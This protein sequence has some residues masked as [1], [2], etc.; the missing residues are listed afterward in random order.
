MSV[1]DELR[2]ETIKW[3]ERIEKLD[4]DGD[5]DFVENVRAYISDSRYFLEKNDLIRAF[6]CVVWAWAWL[7][8]GKR[9]RF[10][11]LR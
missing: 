3:L 6:E 9:Y 8:I 11:C 10:V 2:R 1:E 7:E 4:F 5:K